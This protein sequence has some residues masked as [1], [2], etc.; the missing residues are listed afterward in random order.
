MFWAS[1]IVNI[2]L[3]ICQRKIKT[4]YRVTHKWREFT[5]FWFRMDA[6]FFVVSRFNNF[7][8][9]D[10][11]DRSKINSNHHRIFLE[12][13]LY[14]FSFFENTPFKLLFSNL[15]S[16]HDVY[17]GL[18]YLI[19]FSKNNILLDYSNYSLEDHSYW[20]IF[21]GPPSLTRLQ[22]SD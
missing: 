4:T 16:R 11:T 22:L 21:N 13:S 12:L 8:F 18:K 6:T 17:N 19:H 15:E 14:P 20:E 1:V 3:Q 5:T 10:A 2:F 7:L 9:M